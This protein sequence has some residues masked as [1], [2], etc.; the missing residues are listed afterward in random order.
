MSLIKELEKHYKVYYPNLPGFG[1]SK[2][3]S[4]KKWDLNDFANFINDYINDN[5]LKIYYI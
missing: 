1:N 5:N 2:E 4:V 3:P